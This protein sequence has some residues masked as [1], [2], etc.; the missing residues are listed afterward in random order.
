M[1]ND[2][3]FGDQKQIFKLI[4]LFTFYIISF[5][6]IKADIPCFILIMSDSDPFF[7]G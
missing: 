1:E 2:F 6:N 3:E 7:S 4:N 5:L